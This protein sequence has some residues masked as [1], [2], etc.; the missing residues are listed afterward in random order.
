MLLSGAAPAA[1]EQDSGGTPHDLRMLGEADRAAYHG[2]YTEAIGLASRAID[3]SPHY[4]A[5]YLARARLYMDS[6]LYGEALADLD[7][8]AAMH[9]DTASIFVMRAIAALRQRQGD[10]A[11]AELVHAESA[12]TSS[13]WKQSYEAGHNDAG[14]G[15]GVYQTVTA[16]SVSYTYAYRSI[17]HELQGQDDAALDDLQNALRN[18][19]L[20]PWYVLGAH[21]YT[22]GIAGLLGMAELTC[23]EAIA[24]QGHDTGNYDS[25]GLVHLKM[26][27]WAKAIADYGHA[28]DERPDL[29]L[30]LYGRGVA[31][32]AS[33]DKAGG[34]ADIAAAQRGEPD[35]AN[36][37]RRLG[38]P[39][40]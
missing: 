18:E 25:L 16:H 11:M 13:L 29:T 35:I 6:G 22:A 19:T 12:P 37:M 40:A 8:V 5:G 31:R 38:A 21:C 36:I 26:H 3:D 32:R 39:A 1:A 34:D 33:G 20:H 28:L 27:E 9:P 14:G 7:R 2:R 15:Y 23:T 17:A 10:R 24:R 30:S 4:A